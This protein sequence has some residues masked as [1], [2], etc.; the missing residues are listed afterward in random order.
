MYTVQYKGGT[1]STASFFGA[2]LPFRD[3]AVLLCLGH[4]SSVS[5]MAKDNQKGAAMTA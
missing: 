1:K 2:A 5:F 3:N 4:D